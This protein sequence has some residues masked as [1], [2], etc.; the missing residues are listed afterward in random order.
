MK[1]PTINDR[2]N[3]ICPR[4]CKTFGA[5]SKYCLFYFL[6]RNGRHSYYPEAPNYPSHFRDKSCFIIFRFVFVVVDDDVFSD[7]IVATALVP[8]ER[9]FCVFGV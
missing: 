3:K 8:S 4:K 7:S 6:L 2:I 1:Q 9:A 5:A